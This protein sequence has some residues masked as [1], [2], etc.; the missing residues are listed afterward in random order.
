MIT[1]KQKQL[2]IGEPLYNF[3]VKNAAIIYLKYRQHISEFCVWYSVSNNVEKKINNKRGI[4]KFIGESLI[5][6]N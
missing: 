2:K 1:G 6:N 5:I 3:R 4:I